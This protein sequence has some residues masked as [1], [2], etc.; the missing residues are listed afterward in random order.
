MRTPTFEKE[1]LEPTFCS[2]FSAVFVGNSVTRMLTLANNKRS[3]SK[4]EK[5]TACQNCACFLFCR[6][7]KNW[8]DFVTPF[9][10]LAN[11]K[12]SLPTNSTTPDRLR[13]RTRRDGEDFPVFLFIIFLF[14]HIA[15][16][17]FFQKFRHL[18]LINTPKEAHGRIFVSG[19]SF[20]ARQM[21]AKKSLSW[22]GELV[23]GPRSSDDLHPKRSP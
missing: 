10:T 7:R 8:H 16:R 15:K 3:C 12:G 21:L 13:C 22:R 17:K 18:V 9:S 20:F 23:S 2:S 1:N 11:I 4:N 19:G 14:Q 5:K 6:R